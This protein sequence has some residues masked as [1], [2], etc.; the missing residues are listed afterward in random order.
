MPSKNL[1]LLNST[2]S[3]YKEIIKSKV[4]FQLIQIKNRKHG[5]MIEEKIQMMFHIPHI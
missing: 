2:L 4:V 3:I 5:H 1:H